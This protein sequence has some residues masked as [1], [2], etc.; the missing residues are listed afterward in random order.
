M[1][2]SEALEILKENNEDVPKPPRLPTEEEV[3]LA[4]AELGFKFPADYRKY[5]LEAS[6]IVHG[7]REPGLVLPNPMPYINL[8]SITQKGWAL[9]VPKDYLPFCSDNG[10]YFTIGKSGDVGYMD[11]DDGSHSIIYNQ[12]SDWI[13]EDWLEDED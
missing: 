6:N 4:E 3:L 11:H 2:I 1:E 10:N 7:V 12:L 5:Q 13:I 9:G 8:R